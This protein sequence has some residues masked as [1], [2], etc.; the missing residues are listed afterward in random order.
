MQIPYRANTQTAYFPLLSE[1]MGATVIDGRGDAVYIPNVNPLDQ[2]GPVDR[3]NPQIYY[4][5]NVMPSTY[6]LQSV[7]YN[8]IYEAATTSLDFD[9]IRYLPITSDGNKTYIAWDYRVGQALYYLDFAGVWKVLTGIDYLIDATMTLSVATINGESYLCVANKGVYSINATTGVATLQTINGLNQEAI[10]G[11]V[12]SNGYLVIWSKTGISWSA[13]NDPFDHEP[14]DVT[15][16]GAGELQEAKG[17]IVWCQETSHGFI[18]YTTANAIGCLFS[19]NSDYPFNFKEISGAG[20]VS[21]GEMVSQ[22]TTST[23]YAYTTNGIQTIAHTGAKTV[24]AYVT[25]FLAGKVF[26]DYDEDLNVLIVSSLTSPMR[27]K[28]SLVND[29]YLIIS[30]GQNQGEMFTHAV[31]F[32][33][34]QTRMGKLKINHNASFQLKSILPEVKDTPR[35]TLAFINE[36]GMIS[37]V[38]FLTRAANHDG[39]MLMGKYKVARNKGVLLE[40]AEIQNVLGW[41]HCKTWLLPEMSGKQASG[42]YDGYLL[43]TGDQYSKIASFPSAPAC[44]AFSLQFRG[45]FNIVSLVLNIQPHGR[46]LP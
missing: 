45:T 24:L 1:L 40:T 11:I 21:S 7:G 44:D 26:E 19:G 31:V 16:A 5:H 18:A 34:V 42:L 30:Y 10:Q 12:A 20:G 36:N 14:S 23:H 46:T 37:T 43:D 15:G 17:D 28:L 35:D 29:R 13:T 39:V 32:D 33:V 27:K 2:Y 4:C 41:D 9:A 38:D 6:G 22:E 3:G 8:K 25:D